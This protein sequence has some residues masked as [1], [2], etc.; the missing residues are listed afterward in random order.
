MADGRIKDL[1][2]EISDF[3]NGDFIAVDGNIGSSK[4]AKDSLL[5][6]TAQ[7]ALAGNVAPAFD[8]TRTSENQYT[9]GQ[10]C[11]YGGKSYTF[12]NNH[13]GAW[14]ASDV[15]ASDETD[16]QPLSVAKSFSIV[17]G[18][19]AIK[20]KVFP[21]DGVKSIRIVPS[22]NPWPTDTIGGTNPSILVVYAISS[23]GGATTLKNLLVN[24]TI[25]DKIDCNI[26]EGTKYLKFFIRANS[27]AVVDFVVNNLDYITALDDVTRLNSDVY[28]LENDLVTHGKLEVSLTGA[29]L[30]AQLHYIGV[31]GL[32]KVSVSASPN[33]WPT[34]TIG[35]TNPNI[36]ILSSVNAAGIVTDLKSYPIT[37]TIPDS[38]EVSLPA[39]AE[40]LMIFLRANS[41][42]VVTFS[43]QNIIDEIKDNLGDGFVEAFE[44][45]G[46][47]ATAIERYVRISSG[48]EF[49]KIDITPSPW[50]LWSGGQNP[51]MY[52]VSAEKEDGTLIGTRLEN[53]ARDSGLCPLHSTIYRLPEG[54]EKLHFFIRAGSASTLKIKVTAV[55]FNPNFSTEDLER[56]NGNAYRRA[57]R[58]PQCLLVGDPHGYL[59][60]F[61]AAVEFSSKVSELDFVLCVGD[62]CP[63][64]PTTEGAYDNYQELFKSKYP[65]LPVVGN[66]DTGSSYYIGN[67]LPV[68]KVVENVMGPAIE[69]GYIPSNTRGY[70]YK[71]FANRNLRVIVLNAYEVD[72]LYDNENSKWKRV[73]YDPSAPAIAFSTSY[74]AGDK[75]NI[76]GW[77]DYT[78]QADV[79][80]T[81]PASSV[82]SWSADIPCWRNRRPDSACF[83]QTQA[84]WFADTLLSTP[85]NYGVVVVLHTTFTRN[86]AQK[87]TSK[88]NIKGYTDAYLL[89]EAS[90][91]STTDFLA[92][93]VDAFVR[94][95]NYSETIDYST[96]TPYNV[97]CDFTGKN[98][99]VKF[100]GFLGGH[101][102]KDLVLEHTTYTYQKGVYPSS[103]GS[104]YANTDIRFLLTKNI[105]YCNFTAIAFDIA[106]EAMQLVKVGAKLTD[107]GYLRDCERLE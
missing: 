45:K 24:S 91:R 100:V 58:I 9:I 22:P 51:A 93:V 107:D 11:I 28:D 86:F 12:I 25:P 89:S 19:I 81:T 57:V 105:F 17:G 50:A 102:H 10:S 23:V 59:E 47:N 42:S 97:T 36:L 18:N 60:G 46:L 6:V 62:I 94:G 84:Q 15:V 82:S 61:K 2:R 30:T 77:T 3:S 72:G 34:D 8:P 13:Y 31:K 63:D 70:Y 53:I 29:N 7:N 104:Y 33:P 79:N 41:G 48:V 76:P 78:Y 27:G 88:F 103:I 106:N 44:V 65:V 98:D 73:T 37:S 52:Q 101:F 64:H 95:V 92:D 71:D 87:A 38:I 40:K 85:A 80:V 32:S 1:N 74:T 67:Y 49:I 16:R 90:L 55:S 20:Y 5:K 4:M 96:I 26:P 14:N 68:E 83:T 75:V 54:T 39:G 99:G 21:C 69:K 66:H 56:V 43:V 35:G